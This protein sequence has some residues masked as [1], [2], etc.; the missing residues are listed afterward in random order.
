M[1]TRDHF[2]NGARSKSQMSRGNEMKVYRLSIFIVIALLFS[3]CV[4]HNAVVSGSSAPFYLAYDAEE[5]IR[6]QSQVATLTSIIGLEIDGVVVNN[7]NL[8]STF[9]GKLKKQIVVA[10]VM[11]GTH[12]IKATHDPNGAPIDMDAISYDFQAGRIY[13]VTMNLT[14]VKVVY[15]KSA[16]VAQKISARRKTAVFEIKK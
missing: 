1:E 12:T 3:G 6:D 2:K 14:F 4:V 16:N 15:N 10:D 7:K 11:P 9:S 13:D 5:V 8:R